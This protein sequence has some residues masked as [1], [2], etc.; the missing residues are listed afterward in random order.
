MF[1]VQFYPTP[2]GL[3]EKM[4]HEDPPFNLSGTERSWTRSSDAVVS[5]WEGKLSERRLPLI[6]GR[7]P[8]SYHDKCIL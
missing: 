5:A 6:R 4:I 7:L 8:G 3:V 1:G 2:E